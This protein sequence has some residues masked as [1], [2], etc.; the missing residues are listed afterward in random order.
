MDTDND[1]L[2]T[3][4]EANLPTAIRQH[5]LHDLV[6]VVCQAN[7]DHKIHDIKFVT[8]T[9]S[10]GT[11]YH[12]CSVEEQVNWLIENYAIDSRELLCSNCE[13]QTIYCRTCDSDDD[14]DDDEKNC[15]QCGDTLS[16]Q[17]CY[18][19]ECPKCG[20]DYRCKRCDDYY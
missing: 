5:I 14:D 2:S 20:R 16:C 3:E 15:S 1:K 12:F 13:T 7:K 10:D 18:Q 6:D 17:S 4:I 9:A 11:K 19:P 8:F